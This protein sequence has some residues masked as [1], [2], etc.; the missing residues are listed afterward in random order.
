MFRHM[1][2][3]CAGRY[4]TIDIPFRSLYNKRADLLMM[5]ESMTLMI[6]NTRMIES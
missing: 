1:R 6:Y 4:V 3:W 5:E 2:V